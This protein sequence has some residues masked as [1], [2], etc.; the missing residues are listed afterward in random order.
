MAAKKKPKFPGCRECGHLAK[1]PWCPLCTKKLHWVGGLVKNEKGEEEIDRAASMRKID[2]RVTIAYLLPFMVAQGQL[3]KEDLARVTRQVLG[4]VAEK[5]VDSQVYGF[6]WGKNPYKFKV[7][8]ADLTEG[9]VPYVKIRYAG[10]SCRDHKGATPAELPALVLERDDYRCVI[11]GKTSDLAVTY[12]IPP[13]EKGQS[14]L[15]NMTTFC[16]PCI[17]ERGEQS[18]WSFIVSKD[19]PMQELVIDFRSGYVRSVV[20]GNRLLV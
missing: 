16:R 17:A 13:E 15:G 12:L 18:Y 7:I 3:P 9:G 20:S 8:E 19:I 1:H 2:H 10:W 11:C 5:V 14:S 4:P 6:E